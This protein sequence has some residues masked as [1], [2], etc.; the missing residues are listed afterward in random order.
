MKTASVGPPKRIAVF[1]MAEASGG[2]AFKAEW[3]AKSFS[4]GT[5][6]EAKCNGST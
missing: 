1:S 2:A 4:A 5:Q 6:I 3:L